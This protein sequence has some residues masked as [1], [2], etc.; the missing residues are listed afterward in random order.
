MIAAGPTMK[1]GRSRQDYE[2]PDD[3]LRAVAARFGPLE[4][5][6]AASA[7][8]AKA[9]IFVTPEEDSLAV[10]W[11]GRFRDRICWLN[12]PFA[13]IAPWAE[14]CAQHGPAM[15]KGL[16]LLLTPASIGAEWFVTHV[17]PHATSVYSLVGRLTFV[18]SDGPYPKDCII[19][20]FMR[21]A[22]G[23]VLRPWRWRLDA[24]QAE[25]ESVL[26]LERR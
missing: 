11:S 18:G 22:G 13:N 3:L 7:S 4:V 17:W 25:A 23:R 2:T 14:K 21:M 26:D 19:S 6:L 12:P 24:A 15:G 9:P 10:D 5:D 1:R 20:A 8:N 16:I